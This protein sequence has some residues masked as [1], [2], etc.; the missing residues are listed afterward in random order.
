ARYT[1]DPEIV[2]IDQD[3]TVRPLKGGEATISVSLFDKS[4]S[5]PILVDSGDPDPPT[6]TLAP[7][8]WTNA[9]EV[10]VT[11]DHEPKDH[12]KA[13]I[14]TIRIQIDDCD[15]D[16]YAFNGKPFVYKVTEEGQTIF[17]AQIVDEL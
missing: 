4:K 13:D 17:R 6:I 15:W 5:F 12:R 1:I 9:A 10:E 8:G 3:G 14:N 7:D 2:H 16:D 11:I